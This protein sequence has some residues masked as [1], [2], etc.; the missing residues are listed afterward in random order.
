[1]LKESKKIMALILMSIWSGIVAVC[2]VLLFNS[3]GLPLTVMFTLVLIYF[4]GIALT[5]DSLQTRINV[6]TADI[7]RIVGA[8]N[9]ILNA[10]Q[11]KEQANRNPGASSPAAGQKKEVTDKDLQSLIS[12]L[13]SAAG[14]VK[15]PGDK[16]V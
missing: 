10:L 7:V 2:L 3:F 8:T 12:N 13:R 5:F 1:M 15:K 11:P 6:I 4:A 9:Q 16:K 14:G